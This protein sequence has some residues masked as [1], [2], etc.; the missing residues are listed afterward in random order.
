TRGRNRRGSLGPPGRHHARQRGA[1]VEGNAPGRS[2]LRHVLNKSAISACPQLPAESSFADRHH[3][4]S[5][6]LG[7]LPNQAGTASTRLR[8]K[9]RCLQSVQS[10]GLT[11]ELS[12]GGRG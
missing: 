6:R 8:Q 3:T 5:A 7:A 12:R 1:E 2:R 9:T 11:A 10:R 4:T